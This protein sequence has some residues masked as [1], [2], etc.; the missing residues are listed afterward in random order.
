MSSVEGKPDIIAF[1]KVKDGVTVDE[2]ASF[3]WSHANKG[4]DGTGG[5]ESPR[6]ATSWRPHYS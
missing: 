4:T 5:P 3:F 2:Y 6:T 1:V